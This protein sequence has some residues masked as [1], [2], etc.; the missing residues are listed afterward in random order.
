MHLAILKSDGGDIAYTLTRR[1]GMKNIR[2]KVMPDGGIYV[3][4]NTA[5]PLCKIEAFIL[6]NVD[7]I[8]KNQAAAKP[9]ANYSSLV[10][11]SGTKV[12]VF[13]ETLTLSLRRGEDGAVKSGGELI[14]TSPEPESPAHTQQLL[15]GYIAGEGRR[16]LSEY[17]GFFFEK[18]GYCGAKPTLSLKM[19][20]SKW[21]HCDHKKNE[22][23]LNFA[24]C[25]LPKALAA[26]VAA[27]EV[28]HLLVPN[29]SA[30]FYKT[31]E[32]LLPGFRAY[33]KEMRSYSTS[34]YNNLYAENPAPL[35]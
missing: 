33:D 21:G 18:S 32:L 20:K 11:E 30:L 2:I 25:C 28:A 26:Y 3:S 5:V 34:L 27:H 23:M 29:H 8:R 14:I 6:T 15:L 10:P 1:K 22:I 24:L 7:W 12:T 35:K 13:G 16:V 31:G 4:A 19:L 17:Y 9:A